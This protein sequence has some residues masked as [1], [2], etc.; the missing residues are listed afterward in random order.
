MDAKL[1]RLL[2]DLK[3][4]ISKT[5]AESPDVE[6]SMER[7][8]EEGWSVYLVVDRKREDETPEGV[9]LTADRGA[10]REVLFR[11]DRQDLEFLRS[12]GIDPTRRLR[13]RRH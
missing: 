11:I 12:L 10:A 2:Q 8:R 5:L 13:R 1:R 6:R 9:E 7:I 4:A 3:G